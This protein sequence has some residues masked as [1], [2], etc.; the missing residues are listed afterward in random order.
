MQNKYHKIAAVILAG[1]KSE[2]AETIKGLRRIGQQFW[3]DIL[4]KHFK[5]LGFENIFV[6]LGYNNKEYL[7]KSTQLQTVTPCINPN[8][9]DGSFST[10]Q[11]VLKKTIELE[12]KHIVVMH[13]DHA[14]PHPVT[15]EKLVNNN[16]FDVSKP[17]FN[18]KSGHP[19]VISHNFCQTLLSKPETSI[20]NSEL[21]K[22][23]KKQINW[24]DVDDKT[25][26]E[27]MNSEKQWLKYSS[28]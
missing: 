19:I 14:K 9:N 16:N 10:L 4:I 1:G 17:V 6:G 27:N 5:D 25:I 8:P 12:W 20:L 7:S 2:R 18:K 21:K 22:L 3:I 13:I 28:I 23:S 24:I 11:Y 15:I 26:H